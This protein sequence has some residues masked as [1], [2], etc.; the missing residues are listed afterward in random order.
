MS[1]CGGLSSAFSLCRQETLLSPSS[2]CDDVLCQDRLGFLQ[3]LCVNLVELYISVIFLVFFS[4][5]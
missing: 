3:G 5:Y 2:V 1:E 4:F